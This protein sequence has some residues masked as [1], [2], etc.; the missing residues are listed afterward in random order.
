MPS[1]TSCHALVQKSL[2]NVDTT[3]ALAGNPNV[4]KSTLFNTLTGLQVDTANYPGKTVELNLGITKYNGKTIGLIDLPGTYSLD[5]TSEDQWVARR[6]IIE[7]KPDAVVVIVDASNLQRNLYQTLQL[8]EL[9]FPVVI[10]LNLI[11][12]AER[13]GTRTDYDKLSKLLGAPVIPMVASKGEGI[14]ELLEYLTKQTPTHSAKGIASYGPY[15]DESV[16]KLEEEIKNGLRATPFGMSART[17]AVRLLEN[18]AEFTEVVAAQSKQL[19][20]SI[21]ALSKSIE[22]QYHE[23]A[24]LA[25]ARERHALAKQITEATQITETTRRLL[26]QRAMHYAVSPFTGV[27]LAF[28]VMAGIFVFMLNVGGWLGCD[29]LPLGHLRVTFDQVRDRDCC[30]QWFVVQ[31]PSLGI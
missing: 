11:D 9:E 12:H 16:T 7:E 14:K 26:S 17:L 4:G 3:V 2:K 15:I 21:Q 5:P 28:L 10:A 30:G 1:G 6:G 20:E 18:D 27:P 8:I 25:I 31:N 22:S 29:E 23:P 13:L 19:I 24:S